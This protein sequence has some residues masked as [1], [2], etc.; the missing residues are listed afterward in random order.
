MGGGGGICIAYR[1]ENIIW[2]Y[3]CLE[4]ALGGSVLGGGK[5]QTNGAWEENMG[6]GG[7]GR[8]NVPRYRSMGGRRECLSC[9]YRQLI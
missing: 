7:G 8:R 5:D 1:E 4:H 3:G 2:R 9:L 6:G